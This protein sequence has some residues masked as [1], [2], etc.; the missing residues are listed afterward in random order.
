MRCNNQVETDTGKILCGLYQVIN[1]KKQ[2][3]LCNE[4]SKGEKEYEE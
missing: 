3:F 2:V 4:C 1:N